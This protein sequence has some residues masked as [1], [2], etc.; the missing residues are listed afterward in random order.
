MQLSLIFTL[1]IS[2]LLI[3]GAVSS[4]NPVITNWVN[5]TGTGYGGYR[6]DIKKIMYTSTDVY[7]FCNSIPSYTI[8]PWSNPNVPSAQNWILKFTLS[9]SA[10]STKTATGLGAIGVWKNG[11]AMYNAWDGYSY[12]SLGVWNRNAYYWEYSS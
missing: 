11:V 1:S 4:L 6:A 8:G 10:A 3:N 12:N 7:I 5:S 2:S 9:P